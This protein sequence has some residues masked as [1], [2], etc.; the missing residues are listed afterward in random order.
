MEN[1]EAPNEPSERDGWGQKSEL[2]WLEGLGRHRIGGTVG[3]RYAAMSD[4]RRRG[5]RVR[6][7]EGYLA[8]LK[9][10]KRWF[11]TASVSVLRARAEGLLE[12]ARR[13]LEAKAGRTA[14]GMG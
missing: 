10:R 6:C 1:Q 13:E 8:S 11:H 3:Y 4:E 9:T 2:V 14:Q 7:L 5:H 12:S